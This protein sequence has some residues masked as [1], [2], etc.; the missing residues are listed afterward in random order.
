MSSSSSSTRNYGSLRHGSGPLAG[1]ARSTSRS[2]GL[3][4]IYLQNATRGSNASKPSNGSYNT[5]PTRTNEVKNRFE[6]GPTSKKADDINIS[7]PEEKPRINIG[8]RYLQ[9]MNS[10]EANE[11]NI[12]PTRG[13]WRESV[14]GVQYSPKEPTSPAPKT[15]MTETE[16]RKLERERQLMMDK[17][18]QQS[19]EE[20]REERRL[21]LAL[22]KATLEKDEAKIAEV[23]SEIRR[24]QIRREELKK[25]ELDLSAKRPLPRQSSFKARE[26]TQKEVSV[27]QKKEPTP[28]L[29]PDIAQTALNFTDFDEYLKKYLKGDKDKRASIYS[30]LPD[31]DMEDPGGEMSIVYKTRKAKQL[32]SEMPTELQ[33][34]VVRAHKRPVRFAAIMDLCRTDK[35]GKEFSIES[36]RNFKGYNDVVSMI[37]D[38][39]FDMNK[40]ENCVLQ[41]YRFG[42]E[43]NYFGTYLDM[44]STLQEQWEEIKN[45][46]ED[47][48]SIAIVLRTKSIVRVQAIINRLYSAKGQE[49]RRALF[50]LKQIFMNDKDLV[51]EF[52]T[53]SGLTCLVTVGSQSEHTHQNYI[54]R[55]LGQLILYVD[56]MNGVSEHPDTIR[57]LYSLLSCKFSLVKKTALH[58]LSVFVGYADTNANIFVQT[59]DD[60]HK[61]AKSNG[62][63]WSYLI[64]LLQ[65][66]SGD[67][68][69]SRLTML[70]INKV[71]AAVPDQETFYDI[72][73]CLEVQGM[74]E[75]SDKLLKD[76]N[77]DP[78]LV[79]QL[80][81]YE[82]SLIFEDGGTKSQVNLGE[83]SLDT[84]R[85]TPRPSRAELAGTPVELVN[86]EPVRK[87]RSRRF[88]AE[89]SGAT[90]NGSDERKPHARRITDGIIADSR[91]HTA[92]LQRQTVRELY[93]NLIVDES[94]VEE[95]VSDEIANVSRENGDQ[96][97]DGGDSDIDDKPPQR[98][99]SFSDDQISPD[100]GSG[101]KSNG[102]HGEAR[103]DELKNYQ[104][105]L[106]HRNHAGELINYSQQASS[107]LNDLVHKFEEGSKDT[108][109]SE[110]AN[111][112]SKTST[113]KPGSV[114]ATKEKLAAT[115]GRLGMPPGSSSGDN[116]T[117]KKVEEA[118]PEPPKLKDVDYFWIEHEKK[119]TT[120]PLRVKDREFDDL[121]NSEDE[122]NG[123]SG[124]G[125]V[126]AMNG[127]VPPPPPPPPPPPG[128]PL[129][130]PPP[131]PPP[132]PCGPGGIP[133]PP[134]PFGKS[135]SSNSPL[136]NLPPPPGARIQK[137][138]RTVRLHWTEWVPK[139][140]DIEALEKA[141]KT[142]GR[143]R[144][145]FK[146]TK[147]A[148]MTSAAKEKE[149]KKVLE[150]IK[151][152]T[153]WTH[154]IP[155]SLDY[156]HLE[157]LFENKV[158]EIKVMKH[159]TANKKIEI[160]DVKRSNAINIGM[161]VLPPLRTISNALVKMDSSVINREGIEQLLTTM[162][163][164]DEEREK[165]IAAKREHADI[166]LGKAEEFLL[167]LSEVSHLKARLELWLFKLDYESMEADII[168]PLTDLKQA[169]FDIQESQTFLCILSVILA[170][171]NFLNSSESWGFNPDYLDRLPEVKDTKHK[172]SLLHHV[173]STVLELFPESTDLHSE[174]GAV[175][176]CHRV[177]WEELDKRLEKVE[178][179]CRR[180]WEHY[181]TI[182]C[183][184]NRNFIV[185]NK[186]ADFIA[187]AADRIIAMKIIKKRVVKRYRQ[188]L[189]YLGF[190]PNRAD[191]MAIGHFCRILAEFSLEYRTTRERIL[192]QNAKKASD[193]ERRQTRGKL[194]D[195]VLNMEDTSS[196]I[197]HLDVPKI[198]AS[199][200]VS[201]QQAAD[202]MELRQVLSSRRESSESPY[203]FL[204]RLD[205]GSRRLSSS[206][207]IISNAKRNKDRGA[208]PCLPSSVLE[209]A[210]RKDSREV[211]EGSAL[212][213]ACDRASSLAPGGGTL[214][215][216]G[217]SKERRRVQER[218]RQASKHSSHLPLITLL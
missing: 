169:V 58:L 189:V 102:E 194:I 6:N 99:V 185:N 24:L 83:K 137:Q 120:R 214:G 29:T 127:G 62:K 52:V 7:P 191:S 85:Q 182:Y 23:D 42:A 31:S 88:F 61:S 152:S 204:P 215:R 97:D 123:P 73:D 192:E 166:Q 218:T 117:P 92:E 48:E 112:S 190:P 203:P 132:P 50:S 195:D 28:Q 146:S 110:T 155:V 140:R 86:G 5:I 202:D 170:M 109:K 142:P 187:D 171:G 80:R 4:D 55:A 178:N 148:P 115:I 116:A 34:L 114:S 1:Y 172:H 74:Q 10:K 71:L 35:F 144:V 53:H 67:L 101:V 130:P 100:N 151:S 20:E 108:A 87:R 197:R 98:I 79:E 63:P 180:A 149:A 111:D 154:V 107:T 156:K 205:P 125:A 12:T 201:K 96:K 93:E 37:T 207:N 105:G 59:V 131:P 78:V 134:P 153:I 150:E 216:R 129:G 81:I 164:T 13:S 39:G 90:V 138:N 208:S 16:R 19:L 94:I 22:R 89:E 141:A 21:R 17:L 38:F 135:A 57:W 168:E 176:R 103:T 133:P 56:G 209:L 14:Y 2:G 139:P 70:L 217:P 25:R 165:I 26:V 198:R 91:R 46:S 45:T 160:L 51:H 175:C 212:L 193:K 75:I 177:D 77:T 27:T 158:T 183:N 136:K 40:L 161:K 36:E 54:L 213:D 126:P 44:D 145:D 186:L 66:E 184:A 167:T 106:N 84:I 47:G 159:D 104:N 15:P 113:I 147:K 200:A 68:E 173:C 122:S 49:L 211:R 118:K 43:Q 9:R 33:H 179:D 121:D 206:S 188:L 128:G 60:F 143:D 72:T 95:E 199:P 76:P 11:T 181:Q 30:Y 3:A 41:V 124:P 18:H 196:T 32:F 163:P 210:G 119:V 82:A 8:G 162:L 69:F 157:E 64:D 65:N 174:M